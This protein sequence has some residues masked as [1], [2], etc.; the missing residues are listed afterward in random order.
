[1]SR[2][3]DEALTRLGQTDPTFNQEIRKRLAPVRDRFFAGSPN[4]DP[5]QQEVGLLPAPP[6][7]TEPDLREVAI[8]LAEFVLQRGIDVNIA[9][10][11]D[12]STF[13]HMCV[14]LREDAIALESI[15]WLLAHG[16]DPHRPRDNGE[17]ALSLAVKF[18]RIEIVELMRSHESR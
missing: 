4:R 18:G 8:D 2:S 12:G 10:E 14:Q 17:T 9:C 3:L 7:M 16:A 11:A 1:M 15:A 5:H 6:F 13:L